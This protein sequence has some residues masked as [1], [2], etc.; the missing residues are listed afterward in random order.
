MSEMQVSVEN[1]GRLNRRLNVVVPI[2]QLEQ[3]K[4]NRLAELAKKT[5]LDGFRP[6][7][8][9]VKMVEKLYGDSIWGEVI[10]ES[11]QS[12]LWD[13]L[14]KN[15]L[16]PAGQPHIDS[17]KAEPGQDLEYTAVFEVYPEVL[18]PEFKAITLE[19]LQVEI[20][21]NDISEVLEKMRQQHPDWIEVA[22]KAQL[23]DKVTFDIVYPEEDEEGPRKDLELVLE[24]AKIP[25]GFTALLGSTAGER[26]AFSLSASD[27]GAE[28]NSATLHVQK[29]A[30]PKLAELGDAFAKRLGIQ[31]GG[32]EVLRAQL[33]QHM[34]D[35]LDRVLHEKLKTQVIDK[36]LETQG[37]E[38]LPQ[39]LLDQEFQRLEKESQA[40]EKPSD[41]NEE[42]ASLPEETRN[43]LLLVAKRRVTLGLLFSALI[44]KHD[45]QLD[46]NRVR[47][48][49]ER[50]AGVFQLEQTMMERIFKDKNMMQNIHSSVLEG[51]VVD[52]LLEEAA[53]T[54]K[55]AHYS[56][57]MRPKTI[58]EGSAEQ[59]NV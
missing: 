28:T 19:K 8:V 11:L 6:G 15:T 14:K 40:Q 38:E 17:I 10:Q 55:T 48:E 26:V 45:I 25:E 3:S 22:R 7:N 57:I 20:T 53:Y 29:I 2:S 44:E 4:K 35:E 13:A 34:Q 52:K 30:E 41:K 49:V 33:R 32:M 37:I 47:Q 51:Q 43:K 46:E 50:L 23:G 58:T 18:A 9:P 59:A 54:E 31:E 16:N 36:L 39:V 1:V 24:E 5:R 27:K 42:A 21:E 12:S 56:D